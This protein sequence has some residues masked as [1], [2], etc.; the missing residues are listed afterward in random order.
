MYLTFINKKELLKTN[1]LK[2]LNIFDLLNSYK[3]KPKENNNVVTTIYLNNSKFKEKKLMPLYLSIEPNLNLINNYIL[4]FINNNNFNEETKHLFYKKYKIPKRKGGYRDIIDP[5]PELKQLQRTLLTFIINDCKLIPHQN[6]HAFKK[7]HDGYTNALVHRQ[8]KYIYSFDLK[9]FFPS[10]KKELL[11]EKLKELGIFK[12]NKQPIKLFLDLLIEIATFEGCTPQGSPL[13]PHLSN[14]FLIELDYRLN[15]FLKRTFSENLYISRYVDDITVSSEEKLNISTI[16]KKIKIILKQYY[17]N[18]LRLNE[19][20]TKQLKNTGKC[21]ITGIKL[22]KEHE[23]TIGHEK[24]T[25]LKHEL[26][27][28]LIKKEHGEKI[29][30]EQILEIIGYFAYM[31]RIEP[32]YTQYIIQKYLKKFNSPYKTLYKHFTN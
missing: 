32:E 9:N 29:P 5:S 6:A 18:E 21:F 22:N 19:E 17:N 7:N 30:R 3:Y 13:S 14:L 27:N 26:F 31:S 8:S 16:T 11:K 4:D 24:K 1:S 15:L 23:L 20:K 12:L 28:L 2:Q 25:L 10:I